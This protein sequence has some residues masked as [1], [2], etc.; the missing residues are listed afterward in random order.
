MIGVKEV[1]EILG[2]HLI[3]PVSRSVLLADAMGYVLD[4]HLVADRDFPPFHRI[5][6]DGIAIEHARFA[7]GQRRFAI[8]TVVAAG[9]PHYQL[10]DA[11]CCLEVMTGAILPAGTDTVIRYED[12]AIEDGHASI[13]LA[14]LEK[15]QHV[16]PQGSDRRQGETI[17]PS[18]RSVSAAEIGVAA[19]VGRGHLQVLSMPD[20]AVVTTGDELVDIEIV[21]KTHQIRA[22]NG[23]TIQ[24]ALRQ[25]GVDATILHLRDEE[26]EVQAGITALLQDFAVVIFIG[27]SSKGKYDLVPD[28]LKQ[29]GVS[30]HF[31]RVRQRPGKPM[32]FG[33]RAKENVVFALPGNPVSCF[34]CLERYVKPWMLRSM[35]KSHARRT[36]VLQEDFH[37]EPS[38][39]Y[40]LQVN[41]FDQYG[42][43]RA[44]PVPG[45]GSGD[46]AN[47]VEAAAFL[48][49]PAD[50]SYF[51]EGDVFPLFTYR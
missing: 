24:S 14:A 8:E 33:T 22:S 23:Y 36:A 34:M 20:V 29:L 1:D 9:D 50:R 48:E 21:P 2:K 49:L 44:V 27:G 28:T 5:M 39:T 47:L 19:T 32:W 10:K 16:H 25:I 42:S 7:E 41:L 12:I 40:F 11:S 17:V 26:K 4:E 45:H 18:G 43:T 13:A 46:L 3:D 37:F 15:G 38:L 30:E 35:G 51:R 31:Y 6:M